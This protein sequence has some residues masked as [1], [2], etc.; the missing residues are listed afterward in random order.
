[1]FNNK[2][3]KF[4]IEPILKAKN[5]NELTQVEYQFLIDQ[6]GSEEQI[7]A[8][9]QLIRQQQTAMQNFRQLSPKPETHSLLRQRLKEK[10]AIAVKSSF[11]G[12][13]ASIMGLFLS[14]N[15]YQIAWVLALVIAGFCF[16]QLID[17]KLKP[18]QQDII[19]SD[20]LDIKH[21]DTLNMNWE[22]NMQD[23][24]KKSANKIMQ[25]TILGNNNQQIE[26]L[27]K[28]YAICRRMACANS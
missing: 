23:C 2:L 11:E 26:L 3:T 12:L 27:Q 24:I 20:S 22:L 5:L 25:N 13:L 1:M 6:L 28:G 21:I 14:K 18:N 16:N 8:Y 17:V 15:Q 19:L 10:N 7:I 4:D 9:Q